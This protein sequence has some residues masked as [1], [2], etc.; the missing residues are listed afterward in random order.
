MTITELAETV[1]TSEPTVVRFCLKIGLQVYE[2]LRLNLTT[3]L[4]LR[5]YIQATIYEKGLSVLILE[6]IISSSQEALQATLNNLD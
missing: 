1:G 6:K 3:T 2:D 5:F 4:L